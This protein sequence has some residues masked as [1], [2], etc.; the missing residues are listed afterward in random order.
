MDKKKWW[1]L[2]AI[3]WMAVIFIITQLPY[4]TGQKT[5]QVIQKVV[6]TEQQVLAH[7]I[8]RIF[9]FLFPVISIRKLVI[10]GF[11]AYLIK[12]LCKREKMRYLPTYVVLRGNRQFSRI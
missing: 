4:F 7:Q 9:L 5:G 8:M 12:R 6:V 1:I 3:A 11:N 10:K 2:A